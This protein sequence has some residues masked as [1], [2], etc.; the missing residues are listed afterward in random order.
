MRNKVG[1]VE[2]AKLKAELQQVEYPVVTKDSIWKDDRHSGV[3]YVI[4]VKVKPNHITFKRNTQAVD[5][6]RLPIAAFHRKYK[7]CEGKEGKVQ[8]RFGADV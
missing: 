1:N 3:E 4:V 2:L 7:A 6:H 8:V 5:E